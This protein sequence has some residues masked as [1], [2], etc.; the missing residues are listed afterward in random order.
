MPEPKKRPGPKAGPKRAPLFIE[1][2]VEVRLEME[3]LAA[4]HARKL[5]AECVLAFQEYIKAHKQEGKE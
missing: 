5:T 2:P 1:I 3:R 4:A